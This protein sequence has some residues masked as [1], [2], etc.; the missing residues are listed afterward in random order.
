MAKLEFYVGSAEKH[1]AVLDDGAVPRSGEIVSIRKRTY[2]V[3]RVTWAVDHDADAFYGKLR[4]NV[5]LE[6]PQADDAVGQ[7]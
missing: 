2:M 1:I 6:E 4:A 5:E 3:R 7:R